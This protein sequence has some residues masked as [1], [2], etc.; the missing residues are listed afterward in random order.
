MKKTFKTVCVAMAAC[1]LV[2]SATSASA[3]DVKDRVLRFATSNVEGN[4]QVDGLMKFAELMKEK[5]GGKIVVKV[6]TGGTLGKDIQVLSSMHATQVPLLASQAGVAV[7]CVHCVVVV[8]GRHVLPV[9]RDAFAA[10]QSMSAS[11]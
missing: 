1:G 2:L 8:Q 4:P 3:L 6:F 9:Q 11:H 10:G 5:S 7:K